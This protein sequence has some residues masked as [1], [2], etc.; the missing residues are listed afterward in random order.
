MV[1]FKCE[2][3]RI[4]QNLI[5]YHLNSKTVQTTAAAL[6]T[7]LVVCIETKIKQIIHENDD[8]KSLNIP[9]LGISQHITINKAADLPV[10]KP[11]LFMIMP[12]LK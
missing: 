11:E 1:E 4:C 2:I 3:A 12:R 8:S 10:L 6:Y 5:L 7:F 9:A